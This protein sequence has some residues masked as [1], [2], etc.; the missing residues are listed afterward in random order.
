[1]GVAAKWPLASQI[2]DVCMTRLGQER[3]DMGKFGDGGYGVLSAATGVLSAR[4]VIEVMECCLQY[5]VPYG[6]Q[7]GGGQMAPMFMPA[8]GPAPY[9]YYPVVSHPG[10]GPQPLLHTMP[11]QGVPSSPAHSQPGM[12]SLHSLHHFGE[13]YPVTVC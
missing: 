3:N 6:Q 8:P 9:G 10:M 7:M 5:M 13:A 4:L 1:M 12:F 2:Q 11:P